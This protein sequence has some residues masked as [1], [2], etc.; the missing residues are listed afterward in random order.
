LPKEINI[1][2]VGYGYA[3]KTFHAPLIGTV[4][5]LYLHTVVS[6]DPAK[7]LAD[8]PQVRVVPH[9]E[10]AFADPEINLAVIATPNHLHAAQAQ[11]A[12]ARGKHV[13]VDKPFTLTVAEAEN[14]AIQAEQAGR[15][16]AVFH[17]RRWDADF[18][19][20]RRL[21]G[22]GRLGEIIQFE[23][24][25]DRYRPLPRNRCRRAKPSRSWRSS[26]AR[27]QAERKSRFANARATRRSRSGSA[28]ARLSGGP[29]AAAHP[30]CR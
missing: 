2:L 9:T 26:R 4:P 20:L 1:A 6:S 24:H 12:L 5:G 14:L 17:N 13:V 8:H 25:F 23:S 28:P 21:I 3:G 16:L 19:T 22:A 30:A 18:L 27:D 10:A 15:L 7:V 29:A 11:A